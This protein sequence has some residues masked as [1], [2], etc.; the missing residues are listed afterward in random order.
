MSTIVVFNALSQERRLSLTVNEPL[1]LVESGLRSGWANLSTP[2]G[3]V[4]VNAANVA[5]VQEATKPAAPLVPA[6][7]H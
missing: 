3:P 6:A 4:L 2:S 1:D 7:A 5:F